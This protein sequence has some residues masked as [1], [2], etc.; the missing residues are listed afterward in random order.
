LYD[1]PFLPKDFVKNLEIEYKDTVYYDRYV[2][3]MW[4]KAEGLIF[5]NYENSIMEPFEQKYREFQVAIDYG[6]QNPFTM[7][8]F[9]LGANNVWYK[10][11]EFHHSGRE[12]KA[13]KTDNE[14]Y[15]ELKKFVGDIKI[16][17]IIIDPSA[18]SFV[19]LIKK[20]ND[21]NVKKAKNDVL[22]GIAQVNSFIASDNIKIFNTCKKTIEEFGKY[23]WD[24]KAGD[25]TPIK[26]NDHHCL[27][28]S[29][30]VDTEF[31]QIKISDLVGK[32][33]NVI[34]YD[35]A[36]EKVVTSHFYDVCKTG[37]E[38]IFEIELENGKK[39]ECTGDHPILTDFGWV[40]A[41]SISKR[42]SV[43]DVRHCV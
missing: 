12:S 9:G 30:L 29:T 33:G 43:L 22:A 26:E 37:N 4:K 23:A 34:C 13:Q 27:L 20:S 18:S 21:F 15:L 24:T 7:G 28:G 39:I 1:N 5:P 2:L 11:K 17:Q 38:E 35:E 25:D 10:I 31:G 19:A 42:H 16:K 41:D 14:Y 6:I 36:N 3:G 32:T 40:R 8:L